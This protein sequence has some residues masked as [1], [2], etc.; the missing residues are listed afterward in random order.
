[1]SDRRLRRRRPRAYCAAM[2]SVLFAFTLAV[3]TPAV[4]ADSP[5]LQKAVTRYLDGMFA[6]KPHLATFMGDH[7]FD[8]QLPD[9]TPA[10]LARRRAE[11]TVL[12]AKEVARRCRAPARPHARRRH[13]RR[14]PH[15]DGIA[16]ELLYLDEIRDWQWD[17]RL[18]D[19]FP[20]YDPREIVASRLSDIIHGDFAPEAARK[21]SV[22]AQLNALPAFL[23]AEME[24][25]RHGW[26]HPAREYL[27]AAVDDN[28]GR[29]AFFKSDVAPF[30]TDHG[31]ADP[32]YQKALAA[33]DGYQK[34]LTGELTAL[35]QASP[36]DWRLGKELYAKKFA[37]AL[38]TNLTAQA[39]LA[40]SRAAF[41]EARRELYA[42]AVKLHAQLWPAEPP[43]STQGDATT[44]AKLIAR[45]K[46]E[47]S[48]EHP[49]AADLVAAHARN[50]DALRAFI[51]ERDL[52]G[53]PPKETLSVAPMPL[54]KRGSSA[55]EYLAP[56]I[57]DHSGAPWRRLARDL[58]RHDPV[59]VGDPAW[60]LPDAIESYMRGQ[61]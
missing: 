18:N 10:G 34:F 21:K 53:L 30:V 29:I 9:L 2:R 25:L 7:R 17:P 27:D 58:L 61:N 23:A 49:P 16:L 41:S 24:Q 35:V 44:I 47:L 46:D 52:L 22:R 11:L 15:S 19:S 1:M 20:Y 54:F 26:R 4:A 36:G 13:R 3:A 8:D 55:A 57:L 31:A 40:Q 45:V 37:L 39:A 14:D 6:A 28:L 48:K 33:L 60:P 59:P 5:A 42:H 56:G 51:V 38:G 32:A 12:K 43:A 50:L